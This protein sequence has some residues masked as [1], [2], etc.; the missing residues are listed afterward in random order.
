MSG[1][2]GQATPNRA[3]IEP[4]VAAC[5][6]PRQ[7]SEVCPHCGTTIERVRSD[8]LVGCPLCYEVFGL[9]LA[10]QLPPPRV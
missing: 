9:A 6:A 5:V 8:L 7:V 2:N 3:S 4:L 10:L 1:S